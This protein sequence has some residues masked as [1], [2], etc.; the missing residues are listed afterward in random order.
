MSKTL[1]CGA[2]IYDGTGAVPFQA[3]LL[4]EGTK[5]SRIGR[6]KPENTWEIVDGK[7]MA[8]APGFINTHSHLELELLKHPE[9]R[10]VVEQGITTEILG[11]DGS[12]VAPVFDEN[13]KELM[14]NM[15][16]LA[17][18]M[19]RPYSWRS[20]KEYMGCITAANP[21]ARFEGLV[22]HGTIRMCIMG[23]ENRQATAEE[24]KKMQDLL[25]KCMEEGA[26][27]LSFGLI[28]PPGSFGNTEELIAMAR[29]VAKYDGIIM[30]HM[31]NEKNLLLESMDEMLHVAK[32]SGARLQISHLK[33]L[34]KPNWG[35]VK[36]AL[37]KIQQFN[38][39]GYEVTFDQYP[40]S[41]ACTG[42]KVCAPQWAFSGGEQMF[43]KRLADPVE[44][45]KILS[46]TD[47]E[48]G[49]R[50]GGK[51]ILIASVATEEYSW[52]VGHYMDE[53]A[54][55]LGMEVGEAVLHILQHEGPAVIAIYFSISEEDVALVMQSPYHCACTDGIMG[56]HPHPRTYSSFPRL[57]GHYVRDMKV[58]TLQEAI[59]HITSEPARR[60]RL[61]DRGIIREGM[62]AD[63]VLFDPETICDT[64]SYIEPAQKPAGIR[65]VWV[66]GEARL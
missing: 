2:E 27:G 59:R 25:A 34:G 44:Y 15:A 30:V 10:S 63:L 51:A 8:L 42:L 4:M 11:Q 6:I 33:A 60:L 54:E 23:S 57:L 46:E 64:N 9:V 3:D 24:L 21:A 13:L 28:Y 45:K 49:V 7:G 35:K 29:I 18:T 38:N 39:M 65:Q 50:G 17:G 56:A 58:M 5:I 1:I 36:E 47:Q 14:D 48:I 22:G 26:K 53:I 55:K 43:Q 12:S 66:L 19:D 16:P 61:W 20:Y 41:A 40:W 31:R 52:M 32:E 37:K 62:D